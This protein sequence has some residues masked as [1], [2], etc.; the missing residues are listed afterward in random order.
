VLLVGIGDEPRQLHMFRVWCFN[1][2]YWA[3]ALLVCMLTL[4]ISAFEPYADNG[5]TV[6]GIAGRDYCM[7]AADTRLADGYGISSRNISRIYKARAFR[8]NHVW[9]LFL[10]TSENVSADW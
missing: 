1:F 8:R 4:V 2:I 9:S 3:V 5:G 6:V 7:I 10:L